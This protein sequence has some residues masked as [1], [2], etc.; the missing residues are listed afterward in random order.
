MSNYIN[1]IVICSREIADKVLVRNRKYKDYFEVDFKRAFD[2][3]P[4]SEEISIIGFVQEKKIR[5][6][7]DGRAI[8]S[9]STRGRRYNYEDIYL[10]IGK[11]H[12]I[13]WWCVEENELEQAVF[14]WNGDAIEEKYR[15][16]F[17][18]YDN[19]VVLFSLDYEDDEDFFLVKEFAM[20]KGKQ[21][22]VVED[23]YQNKTLSYSFSKAEYDLIIERI[24]NMFKVAD[25]HNPDYPHAFYRYKNNNSP[26]EESLRL[27]DNDVCHRS[28]IPEIEVDLTLDTRYTDYSK[29][30]RGLRFM[31]E[32]KSFSLF[33]E[34]FCW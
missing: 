22:L 16:L 26:Y 3:S 14:R 24:R 9:F 8:F 13:E 25:F 15:I 12:D 28:G 10:I 29:S 27:Y 1:N 6:L 34:E 5:A 2:Y 33:F 31:N 11:F 17:H 21:E 4:E 23:I 18:Q 20:F 32:I 19:D 7:E 30:D